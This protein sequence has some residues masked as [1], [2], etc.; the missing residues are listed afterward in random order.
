MVVG[1]VDTDNTPAVEAVPAN[2]IEGK[3]LIPFESYAMLRLDE[4][5]AGMA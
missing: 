3:P 2:L 4:P 5:D 1:V